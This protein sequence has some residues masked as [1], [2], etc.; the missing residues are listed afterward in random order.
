MKLNC[1]KFKI[2]TVTPIAATKK[3]TEKYIRE[4][5]NG[6]LKNINKTKNI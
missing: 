2:L 1:H 4:I 5:E 3:V 6:T